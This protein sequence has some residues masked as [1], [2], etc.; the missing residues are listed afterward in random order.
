[1]ANKKYS[2]TALHITADKIINNAV[3]QN[4]TGYKKILNDKGYD[5]LHNLVYQE[6]IKK[7]S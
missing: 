6:L 2:E 3:M 7:Q 4:N 5:Y 1:M